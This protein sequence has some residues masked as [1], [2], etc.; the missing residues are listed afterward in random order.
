VRYHF[1]NAMLPNQVQKQRRVV[2]EQLARIRDL[3]GHMK[4]IEALLGLEP[5]P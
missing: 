4:A 1:V 3:E 2:E 5:R